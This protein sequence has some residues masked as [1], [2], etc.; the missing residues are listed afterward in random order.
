MNKDTI[1]SAEEGS[2]DSDVL[3]NFEEKTKQSCRW[4]K[5]FTY[6]KDGSTYCY[7]CHEQSYRVCSRCKCPFPDSKYFSD[8]DDGK[9]CNACHK[10]YMKEREKYQQ[11]K[12]QIVQQQNPP[13]KSPIKQGV[14]LKRRP[15]T[16]PPNVKRAK[17]E[18]DGN[19]ASPSFI[20]DLM[21]LQTK[22]KK[23]ICF[24]VE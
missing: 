14:P 19:G 22:H 3:V 10:K 16:Q 8:S 12:Q 18:D 6:L 11:Q 5:N 7:T 13:P 4:C 17:R 1:T 9:R 15:S 24:Y 2:D 21:K 20:E 23:R